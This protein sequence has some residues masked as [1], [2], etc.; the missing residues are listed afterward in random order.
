MIMGGLM[1]RLL[2]MI[3]VRQK[4]D[5]FT[6]KD[7]NCKM[8]NLYLVLKQRTSI[9]NAFEVSLEIN[10]QKAQ[11]DID[12]ICERI[13]SCI[14]DY[15]DFC[16]AKEEEARHKN[17]M[18]KRILNL[19]QRKIAQKMMTIKKQQDGSGKKYQSAMISKWSAKAMWKKHCMFVKPPPF[20]PY[21]RLF[22]EV[23]QWLNAYVWGILFKLVAWW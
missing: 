19:F 10:T 16:R 13:L 22:K 17:E 6:T 9:K 7:F 2:N 12:T 3:P 18:P 8:S 11:E 23:C 15:D 1:K 20:I 4:G 14:L 21:P 5:K